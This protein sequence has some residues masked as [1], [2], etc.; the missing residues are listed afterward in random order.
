MDLP[1]PDKLRRLI[2]F[3]LAVKAKGQNTH[4]EDARERGGNHEII[5][6]RPERGAAC[7]FA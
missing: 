6:Y 5:R 1:K 3:A 2:E 7:H 4:D